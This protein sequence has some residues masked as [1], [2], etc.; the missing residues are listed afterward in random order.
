MEASEQFCDMWR[1]HLASTCAITL[2][3]V[4]DYV[5]GVDKQ[6]PLYDGRSVRYVNVDNAATTPPFVPCIECT[7]RF[8]EL[9][10]S[11][12][13]GTG[14]K[15]LVS[16][17]VYEKCRGIVSGFVGADP[18]Y[19]SVIFTPNATH[20]L[21]K[22]AMH[23]NPPN[24]HVI[25]TTKMEHHSNMLPWRKL[26]C[27][28]EYANVNRADGTLDLDDLERKIRGNNGRL[29]LVAVTAASN[30]TGHM[31]PIRR[32]AKLAHE[33]GAM[34]AVDATQLLPHREFDMGA[35]GEPDSIDFAAFSAHKM[36]APFGVGVLVGPREFFELTAPDVVGGGTV[37]VVTTE[38]VR[39]APLPDREEAGTPNVPGAVAL[40]CAMTV[41]KLIGMGNVAEHERALT[42][43]ALS[44]LS[45]IKGLRLYGQK[46]PDI[47]EDRIGVIALTADDLGHGLLAS[48][49]S[50]EWGIG[51][52]NGCFCA[53][54]YVRDLLGV[55]DAEMK[56]IITRLTA[57][58][59]TTVPGMVR[60][61][62]GVYNTIE[63]TD[64]VVE[65]IERVLRD[66]PRGKY[67]IDKRYMEYVLD[68][69]ILSPDDY[70]PF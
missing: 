20:A 61:S 6:V 11:V 9:Y 16:T 39:W 65:A 32:I 38:E 56:Q 62:F 66:G 7:R 1:E 58:D 68:P 26:G 43:R 59:H 67:A 57:G 31:P 37:S 60:I 29:H 63:E 30:V 44:K 28:V 23:L 69:P 2:R 35:P 41:L 55:S 15:S 3:N 5:V 46:D 21:N 10:A 24:D 33:N 22:L 27:R 51:V 54:P 25:V 19:H 4:R 12:H 36:Y 70:M 49:L 52:R 18:S 47:R 42:R 53:Q 14:F 34:I 45:R 8:Y 48:V 40:A 50:Q 13:R 17:R 64:Y